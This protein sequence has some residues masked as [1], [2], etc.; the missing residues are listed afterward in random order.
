MR[1]AAFLTLA[2]Q[3]DFVIDDDLAHAP[4]AR[5]GWQVETV[6]WNRP[7]VD[8]QR[9]DLVAI[10]STWDY[11]HQADAFL[12][13]LAAIEASGARLENPLGIVRWN[14]RK[15]YLRDLATKGV[16][17]V[18]TIWRDGL[19]RGE[20]AAFFEEAHS[21]EA[22]I[23][24]VMSGNAQGAWRL[25]RAD[26]RTRAAEIE[27]Y[28]ADRALMMQP[29]EPAILSEGEFSLLY[30]NGKFSHGILKVPKPGD[31][32][33][34]EEHG[35]EIRAITPEPA[36]LAAGNAA[37][38]AIGRKLLYARADLVRHGDEFRVMELEL[39][40]PAL[41]LRMDPRAPELFADAVVSLF[42]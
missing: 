5:R 37:I 25:D 28:Y 22:V 4:L 2:E 41:Y 32:R 23:K 6:P 38:D 33:V 29:F 13:T 27:A 8:W 1:R 14:M 18:P 30:F 31:F 9:Y 12:T 24:P 26:A 40:E 17:V 42:D 36:L 20:L 7:G 19:R 35:S 21:K 10:R 34:Q 16:P 11:Q 3:G 15:T 39:V